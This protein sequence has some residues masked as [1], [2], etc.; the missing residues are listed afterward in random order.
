MGDR[1]FARR[2]ITNH[3][4]RSRNDVRFWHLADAVAEARHVCSGGEG[5]IRIP[6]LMSANDP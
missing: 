3:C 4:N 2:A 6:R 1:I 5:D